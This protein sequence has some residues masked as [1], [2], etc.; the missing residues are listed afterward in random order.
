MRVGRTKSGEEVKWG[1][2]NKH[3]HF[4]IMCIIGTQYTHTNAH[5]RQCVCVCVCVCLNQKVC[6]C[7]QCVC[8][9]EQC[10][11]MWAGVC[12]YIVSVCVFVC[13]WLD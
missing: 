6:G 1:G 2:A 13:V 11:C 5:H 9:L 7:E 12:V 4:T 8:G 3:T 10:V